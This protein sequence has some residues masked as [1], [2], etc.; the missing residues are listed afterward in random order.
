[1]MWL[2]QILLI[3]ATVILAGETVVFLFMFVGAVSFGSGKH[4]NW[5]YKRRNRR[6]QP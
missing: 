5:W 2:V 1:M 3:I 6:R 4:T